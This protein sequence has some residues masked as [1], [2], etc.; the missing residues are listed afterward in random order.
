MRFFFLLSFLAVAGCSISSGRE[1]AFRAEALRD[2][3][4]YAIA[5]CLTYQTHPYLQDQ[6]DAW[7]SVLVQRMKGSIDYLPKIAE[8]VKAEVDRG[9]MVVIRDESNAGMDKE[10]PILYCREIVDAPAVSAVIQ[11][12]VDSLSPAYFSE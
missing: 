7:A 3:E 5:S 8:K 1:G 2:V 11:E 4:G 10:L 6:G 9:R 12:A